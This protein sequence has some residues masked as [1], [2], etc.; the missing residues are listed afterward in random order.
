M[1]DVGNPAEPQPGVAR[2]ERSIPRLNPDFYAGIQR[3]VGGVAAG[4]S[5]AELAHGVAIAVENTAHVFLNTTDPRGAR[6]FD[7]EFRDH[8]PG[9]LDAADRMI[10]W[11]VGWD[12]ATQA[13]IE[14]LLGRLEQAL[15][16][17]PAP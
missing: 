11:L 9:D 6:R 12:P 4:A 14:T 8:A 1:D 10:D 16:P 15:S 17:P 3:A 5:L 7:Q 2:P 13:A